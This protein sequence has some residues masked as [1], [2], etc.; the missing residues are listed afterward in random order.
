MRSSGPWTVVLATMTLALVAPAR[1]AQPRGAGA[2]WSYEGETG[3][4]HWGDLDPRYAACK[5]GLRQSP[6][7]IAGTFP[8]SPPSLIFHYQSRPIE[9]DERG[10]DASVDHG[11]GNYLAV[12]SKIYRL[13]QLH[14]HHPSEHTLNKEAFPLEA[15]LVHAASDGAKL[16]VAI[17]I[18]PGDP[19]LALP[20]IADNGHPWVDP[21]LLLPVDHSYYRYNGSLTTPPC[22]EGVTWLVMK[23]PI[24]MSQ[25]QL[26][27][28]SEDVE[29]TARPTQPANGR[30]I[31]EVK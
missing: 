24:E 1:A 30:F 28:L 10:D 23:S 7:D 27:A 8:A 5:S 25:P 13:T 14:F 3:P 26:A 4:A 18:K 2:R 11:H 19:S 22:S 17:L 16:V 6:I 31:L 21:A 29:N 15:H 9:L 12:G 20:S